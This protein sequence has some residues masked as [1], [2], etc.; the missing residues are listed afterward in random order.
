ML[1]GDLVGTKYKDIGG[2]KPSVERKGTMSYV[3]FHVR[4]HEAVELYLERN[5]RLDL[6]ALGHRLTYLC[7]QAED[8]RVFIALVYRE[9]PAT[10]FYSAISML[11]C[12]KA[13]LGIRKQ[14]VAMR[15]I[16][17]QELFNEY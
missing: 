5:T 8:D 7:D 6:D 1:T 9:I 17:K 10:S 4:F 11:D 13:L 3:S 2:R 14:Y 15:T 12:L 16:N